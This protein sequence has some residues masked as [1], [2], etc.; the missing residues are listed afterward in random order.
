MLRL[1]HCAIRHVAWNTSKVIRTQAD[2]QRKHTN[3]EMQL[4]P[5]VQRKGS[6]A[7]ALSSVT[8]QEKTT[9]PHTEV[10]KQKTL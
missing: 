1:Q 6:G 8:I 5:L 10:K 7:G 4:R 9:S 3:D 2:F